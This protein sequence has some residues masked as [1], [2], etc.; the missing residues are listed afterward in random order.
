MNFMYL[1]KTSSKELWSWFKCISRLAGHLFH[2]KYDFS[3]HD[4]HSCHTGHQFFYTTLLTT[5]NPGSMSMLDMFRFFVEVASIKVGEALM[6]CVRCSVDGRSDL[7]STET[8]EP[9]SFVWFALYPV[10]LSTAWEMFVSRCEK[11]G[12]ADCSTW[13]HAL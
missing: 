4:V 11:R 9:S 6:P 8:Q 3:S 10:G 1:L 2:L 7:S 5:W 12:Y 13:S